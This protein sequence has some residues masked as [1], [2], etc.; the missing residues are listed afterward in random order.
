MKALHLLLASLLLFLFSC[1]TVNK[2]APDAGLKNQWTL[3]NDNAD[4]IGMNDEP[5][6]I[7]F[8]LEED[9]KISGFAGCNYYGGDYYKTEDQ[10]T[11][12]GVYATKRA[13][14][15][16]D[17]ETEFLQLL[18]SVDRYEIKGNNLYLYKGKLLFL[19]FKK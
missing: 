18:E 12:S 2:I 13:C 19:H 6:S 11:F 16:L 5:I 8:G 4:Q 1:G 7:S 14:P 15:D 3:Q 10:I 9:N 17:T